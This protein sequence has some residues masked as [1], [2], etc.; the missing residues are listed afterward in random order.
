LTKLRDTLEE[1]LTEHRLTIKDSLT[2]NTADDRITFWEKIETRGKVRLSQ[3]RP[4]RRQKTSTKREDFSQS[5]KSKQLIETNLM[6]IFM[7]ISR[8]LL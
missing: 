1:Q 8:I 4:K 6:V 5:A 3:T 7:A 2:V